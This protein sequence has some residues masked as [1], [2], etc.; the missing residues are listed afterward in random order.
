MQGKLSLFLLSAVAALTV[1]SVELRNCVIYHTKDAPP[2]VKL[3]AGELQEHLA[4]VLGRKLAIVHTARTPMIALG[5]TPETRKAGIVT[6][7]FDYEQ[8]RILTKGNNLFIAGRDIKNDGPTPFGNRWG[9]RSYG[10]LYAVY[11]FLE[12]QVGVSF[13]LPGPKGIYYPP[14]NKALKTGKLDL[15]YKPRFELRSMAGGWQTPH[16]GLREWGRRNRHENRHTS[17]PKNWGADHAWSIL[18]PDK[19]KTAKVYKTVKERMQTFRDHPELFALSSNGK[20][21]APTGQFSLCISN[22]EVAKDVAK[23]VRAYTSYNK[24]NYYFISPSDGTPTCACK[25]CQSQTEFLDQK[26][27]GRT[28]AHFIR[29]SW[30]KPVLAYYRA[31]SEMLPDLNIRGLIYQKYE[32]AP[33]G[34]IKKM[35]DNF[36]AGMAPVQTGYG[37]ARL[38]EEVNNTWKKWEKSWRGVFKRQIYDSVEFWLRQYAGAPMSPYPS[39]MKDIFD[40][41]NANKAYMGFYVYMNM[42]IGHSACYNWMMMHLMWN[43]A[44]DPYKLM[45]TFLTKAYGPAAGE[46]RAI[47]ALAERNMRKFITDRKGKFGYNISPELLQEVYAQDWDQFEALYLKALKH[48][49][50]SSTKWRLE[51]LGENLKLLHYHLMQ[52][53]LIAD[54]PS[55]LKLTDAQ[56]QVFNRKRFPGGEYHLLVNPPY[57]TSHMKRATCPLANVKPVKAGE[58]RTREKEWNKT[59]YMYHQ[60]IIVYATRTGEACFQLEFS[61]VNNPR[62]GKPYLPDTP[63]FTVMDQKGNFYY[64]GI[65]KKGRISFPVKKDSYYY[66]FYSP[67]GDHLAFCKWRVVS[68]NMPFSFGPMIDGARGVRMAQMRSPLYFHVRKDLKKMNFYV[69]GY[70]ADMELIDPEGK[71]AGTVLGKDPRKRYYLTMEIKNPQKGYW[72]IRSKGKRPFSGIV[73]CGEGVDGYFVVNPDLALHVE[74]KE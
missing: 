15:K 30:T 57:T 62:T 17:G 29:Q 18:Y 69:H 6:E 26:I 47:Y 56:F 74:K 13:L 4:P 55:P 67:L 65:A 50:D 45:E 37:P 12:N 24:S 48:K 9:G 71:V 28:G 34:G 35:P 70:F 11:D 52:Y 27:I 32:F 43:P 14:E 66:L 58:I 72:K 8:Y 49:M 23:R 16:K 5:D 59:V 41:M 46:I 7:K 31:V 33:S 61:T 2:S 42:G 1:R 60:D 44:L 25:N 3:A 38:D 54:K 36:I 73:R 10:T 68:A 51:M 21:I 20:R 22:P 63:Y 19:S 53:G 40:A 64:H 39:L